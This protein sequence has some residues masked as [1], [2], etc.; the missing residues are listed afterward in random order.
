MGRIV[1]VDFDLSADLARD[2]GE[3]KEGTRES[4]DDQATAQ[5]KQ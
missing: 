3:H 2:V 4:R 1:D 5:R